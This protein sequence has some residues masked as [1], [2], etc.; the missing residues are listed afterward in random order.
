M[1]EGE[2]KVKKNN[3]NSKIKGIKEKDQR[4]DE[5]NVILS[6]KRIENYK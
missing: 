5:R 3:Y 2:G 1:K 6:E 4:I